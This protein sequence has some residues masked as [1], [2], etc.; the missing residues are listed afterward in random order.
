LKFSE[1]TDPE[2][3]IGAGLIIPVP[4]AGRWRTRMRNRS[5]SSVRKWTAGLLLAALI[6]LGPVLALLV[7]VAAEMLV[8][9]L[10]LAGPPAVA[11]M[12]AGVMGW[13]LVLKYRPQARGLLVG[14]EGD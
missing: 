8:D 14:A 12:A 9:V 2:E 6:L 11:A 10:T 4:E 3:R 7:I 1:R 5:E 13:A